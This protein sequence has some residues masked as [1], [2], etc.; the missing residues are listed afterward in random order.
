M[1]FCLFSQNDTS[2]D[3]PGLGPQDGSVT[4]L[5]CSNGIPAEYAGPTGPSFPTLCL[6]VTV[7]GV[8]SPTQ[9]GILVSPPD[10]DTVLKVANAQDNSDLLTSIGTYGAFQNGNAITG[11]VLDPF[12][13]AVFTGGVLSAEARTMLSLTFPLLDQYALSNSPACAL[14]WANLK[15]SAPEW[16]TKDVIVYVEGL[17][18]LYNIPIF[19]PGA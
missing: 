18:K 17:A 19:F 5:D 3:F 13:N 2:R 14:Y 4:Y 10:W 7:A 11:P 16:L 9:V 1:I 15:M 6:P 8:A 12:K